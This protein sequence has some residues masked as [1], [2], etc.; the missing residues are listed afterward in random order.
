MS[1]KEEQ[2]GVKQLLL[3][4]DGTKLIT[5]SMVVSTDNIDNMAIAHIVARTIPGNSQD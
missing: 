3:L 5:I 1:F 2:K 4:E